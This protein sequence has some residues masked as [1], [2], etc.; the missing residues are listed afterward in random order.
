MHNQDCFPQATSFT[1]LLAEM[2][3]NDSG[4]VKK[5]AKDFLIAVFRRIGRQRNGP[6]ASTS[7]LK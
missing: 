4:S 6:A 3:G 2:D 5:V 1:Q 7:H